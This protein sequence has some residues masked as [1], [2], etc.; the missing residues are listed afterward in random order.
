AGAA[1]AARGGR[2]QARRLRAALRGVARS[3]AIEV[4]AALEA[5]VAMRGRAWIGHAHAGCGNA[6][7]AHWAAEPAQVGYAGASVRI[8]DLAHVALHA[9][10][11]RHLAHAVGAHLTLRA[12]GRAARDAIAVAAEFAGLALHGGA[13]IVD[14]H[15]RAADADLAGRAAGREAVLAHAGRWVAGLRRRALVRRAAVAALRP[16][17]QD[18]AVLR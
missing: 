11:A 2:G 13:R 12:A 3:H 16:A 17:H 14:A 4:H 1:T 10:A 18:H 5:A 9:V 6:A 7:L 15:A 8:A